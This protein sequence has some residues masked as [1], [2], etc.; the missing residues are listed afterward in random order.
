MTNS[1]AA[2]VVISH[3]PIT[4]LIQLHDLVHV[5][6]SASDSALMIQSAW[7]ASASVTMVRATMLV[8]SK[9]RDVAAGLPLILVALASLSAWIPTY[10]T[11]NYNM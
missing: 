8:L 3:V 4:V 6:T 1:T 2:S 5:L 10:V 11:L 7:V 9:S